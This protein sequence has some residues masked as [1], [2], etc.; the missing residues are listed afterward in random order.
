MKKYEFYNSKK[1]ILF[2]YEESHS[3]GS[4][5]ASGNNVYEIFYKGDFV[6]NYKSF[7]K[8]CA[9]FVRIYVK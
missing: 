4:I 1:D 8:I 6:T 2:S 9:R 5:S 7:R 3:I